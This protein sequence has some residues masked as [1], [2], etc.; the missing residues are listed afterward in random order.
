[1][2]VGWCVEH[3]IPH[4]EFLTWSDEDRSKLMAYLLEE[5]SRCSSCG[6]KPA[7]WDEDQWAYE[8]VTIMCHGCAIKDA[9]N[10]DAPDLPGAKVTLVPAAVAEFMRSNPR[11]M[12]GNRR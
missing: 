6:T 10:E 8:A 11:T 4:S 7:D 9:A 12:P 2:E 1:M 5:S 3:G